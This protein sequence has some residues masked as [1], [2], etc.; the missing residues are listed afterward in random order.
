[1]CIFRKALLY[2]LFAVAVI[3][4]SVVGITV[5]VVIAVSLV[6]AVYLRTRQKGNNRQRQEMPVAS[7]SV[8]DEREKCRRKETAIEDE[9]IASFP[10]EVAVTGDDQV[11][12]STEHQGEQFQVSTCSLV[13]QLLLH[14]GCAPVFMS[15]LVK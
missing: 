8:H 14:A 10:D 7:T 5:A 15:P 2:I 4:V 12:S 9:S 6:A 11:E 1:M 3:G 13:L